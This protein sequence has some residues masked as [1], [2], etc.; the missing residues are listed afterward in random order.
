M[1]SDHLQSLSILSLEGN[2]I[3]S[4]SHRSAKRIPPVTVTPKRPHHASLHITIHTLHEASAI[5]H[6]LEL[7]PISH[8]RLPKHLDLFI[9][10]ELD[11]ALSVAEYLHSERIRT[12]L[13]DALGRRAR[14]APYDVFVIAARRDDEILAQRAIN[15]MEKDVALGF[16]T[17]RWDEAD[18]QVRPRIYRTVREVTDIDDDRA[19]E[20]DRI[21]FSFCIYATSIGSDTDHGKCTL[22]YARSTRPPHPSRADAVLYLRRTPHSAREP[23]VKHRRHRPSVQIEQAMSPISTKLQPRPSTLCPP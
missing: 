5:S 14:V 16:D 15:A 9:L 1:S 8:H 6:F 18:F 17:D 11:K 19:N 23:I 3:S 4:N 21:S 2:G 20:R 13:S 22:H 12:A 7:C 10:E